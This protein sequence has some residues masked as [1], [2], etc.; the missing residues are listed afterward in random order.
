MFELLKRALA[1]QSVETEKSG[2]LPHRQPESGEFAIFRADAP[3]QRCG[4][5]ESPFMPTAGGRENRRKSR[6]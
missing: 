3:G 6:A 2:R 4:I 1:R 5:G